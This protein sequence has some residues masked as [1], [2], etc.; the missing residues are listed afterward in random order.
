[1]LVG[2]SARAATASASGRKESD[3]SSS[4]LEASCQRQPVPVQLH[5]VPGAH[6]IAHSAE[7]QVVVQPPPVH[8][9]G[10]FDPWSHTDVHEPPVQPTS[11]RALAEHFTLQLPPVHP[12]EH[13][14]CSR[15]V[16]SQLPPVQL[17]EHVSPAGHSHGVPVVQE[18]SR[19][20]FVP[21]SP[22]APTC[23]SYEQ[24]PS[25]IAA[26]TASAA[27]Q[28]PKERERVEEAM[29]RRPRPYGRARPRSPSSWPV[30][31]G[32]AGGTVTR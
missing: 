1:M 4:S 10:H 24:A 13:V 18:T 25:T 8:A 26:G 9:T 16:M 19:E 3:D 11:Q 7:V 21:P 5:E 14:L 6:E 15:Q 12:I 23:Q 27:T 29:M 28:R 17:I 20:P 31:P 2:L 32:R 30:R 22:P